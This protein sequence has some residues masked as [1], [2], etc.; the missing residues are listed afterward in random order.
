MKWTR[1]AII[2][3]LGLVAAILGYLGAHT[4]LVPLAYV[5]AVKDL[6]GL[7]AAICGYFSAS[8]LPYGGGPKPYTLFN[9]KDQS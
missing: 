7:L 3:R 4:S 6:S 2:W 9:G 1:E 5:E 8:P